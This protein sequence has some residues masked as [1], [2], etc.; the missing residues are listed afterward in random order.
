MFF[1]E[2]RFRIWLYIPPKDMRKSFSPVFLVKNQIKEDLLAE[3]LYVFINCKRTHCKVLYFDR[4]GYC[5][6]SKRLE[7]S[8]FHP[9]AQDAIKQVPKWTGLKPILEGGD[10]RSARHYIRYRHIPCPTSTDRLRQSF[11]LTL[12]IPPFIGLMGKPSLLLSE[13]SVSL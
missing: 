11:P 7:Q 9:H 2:S 8:Q 5:L 6:W 4:N 3:Y 1:P 12:S 10:T 13:W